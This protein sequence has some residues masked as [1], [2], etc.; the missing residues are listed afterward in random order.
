MKIFDVIKEN[1][2]SILTGLGLGFGLVA[3][4]A[5]SESGKKA[6]KKIEEAEATEEKKL[7]KKETIKLCWK[8]YAFPAVFEAA[9][10][11]CIVRGKTL[12]LKDISRLTIAYETTSRFMKIYSEKVMEQ[13][14]EQQN[15]ELK[16]KALMEASPKI[17]RESEATSLF[18]G[19]QYFKEPYSGKI[20]VSSTVK[21]DDAVNQ[22]ND[23]LNNND[24]APLYDL[25]EAVCDSSPC[26]LNDRLLDGDLVQFMGFIR[27]NGLIAVEYCAPEHEI[28]NGNKVAYTPVR[29]VDR[30][31]NRYRDPLEYY[32][33]SM[34]WKQY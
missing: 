26:V 25:W 3:V 10:I 27:K 29:F 9:S 2:S 7:T 21:L 23:K 19:D 8:D 30:Q 5:S 13:I 18:D 12:D 24:E 33:E 22:F 16:K 1:K 31:H 32:E 20:F 6:A 15:E 14:G 17:R 34:R 28:F 4:I 11:A